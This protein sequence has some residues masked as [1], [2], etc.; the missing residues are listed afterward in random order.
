MAGVSERPAY[1]A[2]KLISARRA[3][4]I[5]DAKMLNR[6]AV[7]QPHISATERI[8]PHITRRKGVRMADRR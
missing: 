3:S 7:R 5:W 8:N 4:V 1:R 6:F 2:I